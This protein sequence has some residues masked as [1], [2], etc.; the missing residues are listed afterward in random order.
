MR[1]AF[2]ILAAKQKQATVFFLQDRESFWASDTHKCNSINIAGNSQKNTNPKCYLANLSSGNLF[3]FALFHS[4]SLST[5]PEVVFFL[6][7][8][9]SSFSCFLSGFWVHCDAREAPRRHPITTHFSS[10]RPM[11]ILSLNSGRS[12]WGRWRGE[13]LYLQ[14]RHKGA[15]SLLLVAAEDA[16]DASKR[17]GLK[18]LTAVKKSQIWPGL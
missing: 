1:R 4:L 11:S 13:A 9:L 10:C 18:S 8:F 6:S 14:L 7:F 17:A 16:S 5:I 3:F 12:C 2:W 15:G